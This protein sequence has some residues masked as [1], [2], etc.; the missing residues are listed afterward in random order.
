MRDGAG[1]DDGVDDVPA[2]WEG[3]RAHEGAGVPARRGDQGSYVSPRASSRVRLRSAA[4]RDWPASPT[5]MRRGQGSPGEARPVKGRKQG[6]TESA[7]RAK[8]FLKLLF[9]VGSP[10]SSRNHSSSSGVSSTLSPA[11]DIH[12]PD[13]KPSGR[14]GTNLA[15]IRRPAAATSTLSRISPRRRPRE[16]RSSPSHSMNSR[17]TSWATSS[18]TSGGAS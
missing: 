4:R 18:A 3:S 7:V 12:P 10:G 13:G 14:R 15:S 17:Y 8:P 9:C 2:P 5:P 11:R 16:S 6:D 1:D